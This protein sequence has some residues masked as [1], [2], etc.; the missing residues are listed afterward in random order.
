MQQG[1]DSPL[2]AQ[3]VSISCS[4]RQTLAKSYVGAPR[5][6]V[7]TGSWGPLGPLNM[8]MCVFQLL[9]SLVWRE[10]MRFQYLVQTFRISM[11]VN[12]LIYHRIWSVHNLWSRMLMVTR[13]SKA[14]TKKLATEKWWQYF[15]FSCRVR[16][17]NNLLQIIPLTT[18]YACAEGLTN[19]LPVAR[20]E[21]SVDEGIGCGVEGR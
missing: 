15:S 14:Q 1:T 17:N 7:P 8:I 2:G 5:E 19:T 12:Q 16:R 20:H 3:I 11:L 21:Q 6:L 13:M 9:F 4:F 10:V 18:G